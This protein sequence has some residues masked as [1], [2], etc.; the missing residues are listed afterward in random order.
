MEKSSL[1]ILQIKHIS[2]VAED[3]KKYIL[4]RRSGKEKSLR[5]SSQKMNKSLMDGFDW[6]RIITIAGLSGSGKSTL[7]QQWIKEMLELNPVEKFDVLRFQFEM[8]GVDEVA[9]ELSNKTKKNIKQI[10]SADGTLSDSDLSEIDLHLSKIKETPVSIVDNIGTVAEI[11]DTVLYYITSNGL[12][13]SNRGLIITIDHTLLVKGLDADSEKQVLDK[14]MHMLVAL[15]KYLY[16]I[17]FKIMIFVLSQLN[18]DI[19]SIDRVNNPKLHYPTKND[20]FGASS[21]YYSS[22]YVLILHRP[23]LIEGLGNWYGPSRN[24]FPN[25]LPVFNPSNPKQPMIYLHIIKER[26]GHNK[27][28]PLLDELEHAKI[29]EYS[30][31]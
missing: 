23:C 12:L 21:I 15:K 4:N 17:G 11:K 2:E 9:R 8:L 31:E 6:G 16:S 20:L 18:R 26:F 3:T 14:L 22:D 10:Y 24:G 25:G 30:F 19:E 27:I 7:V 28:I 5:V 29:I 13:E 1:K